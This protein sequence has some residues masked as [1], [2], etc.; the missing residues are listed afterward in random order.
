[1]PNIKSAMKR[2]RQDQRKRLENKSRK[3]ALWTYEKKFRGLVQEGN[4]EEATKA[5]AKAIS[6]YDKAAKT[7]AIHQNKVARKK[8]RLTALLEKAQ[9]G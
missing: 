4:L 9:Q 1:M 6:L 7:G 3:T 8:S 2:W 5:L